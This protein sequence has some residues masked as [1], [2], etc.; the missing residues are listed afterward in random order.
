M[1]VSP[2]NIFHMENIEIVHKSFHPNNRAAPFFAAIV[3]SEEEGELKLVVMFDEQDYTAVLSLDA[4]LEDDDISA[5]TH[6]S[7]GDIYDDALREALW[8]S[9]VDFE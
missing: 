5:A 8:Y 3:S 2:Y 6:K 9:E 4:L 7:K 1:I